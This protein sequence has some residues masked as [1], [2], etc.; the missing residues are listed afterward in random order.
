MMTTCVVEYFDRFVNSWN[1]YT[2]PI[3]LYAN[4]QC[5]LLVS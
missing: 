5:Q 3:E 1:Y 4:D 2:R